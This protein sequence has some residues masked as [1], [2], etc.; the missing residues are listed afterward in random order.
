MIEEIIEKISTKPILEESPQKQFE[1]KYLTSREE[2]IPF[3]EYKEFNME[4]FK[5]KLITKHLELVSSSEKEEEEEEEEQ[6]EEKIVEVEQPLEKTLEK[7]TRTKKLFDVASISKDKWKINGEDITN[8]IPP[9]IEYKLSVSTFFMNNREAFVHFINTHFREYKIKLGKGEDITC[10]NLQNDEN[11]FSSLNHQKLIR[12]YLN[13][14]TP[15]RGLLVFHSLGAGKTASSIA[16]GFAT[17]I[18]NSL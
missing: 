14:Y 12:D 18:D 4:L 1:V 15:Y 17:P 6:K 13:L 8:Q 2:D 16:V 5:G 9:P 10:E 3:E 11:N 7:P